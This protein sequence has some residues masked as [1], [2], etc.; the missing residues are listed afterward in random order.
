MAI[1]VDGARKDAE[2]EVK[3]EREVGWLL[4][5]DLVPVVDLKVIGSVSWPCEGSGVRNRKKVTEGTC[6]KPYY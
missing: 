5:D 4:E 3:F 6:T 1:Y 2:T